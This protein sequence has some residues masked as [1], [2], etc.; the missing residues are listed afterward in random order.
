MVLAALVP[1][2]DYVVH[3]HRRKLV[4]T[5]IDFYMLGFMVSGFANAFL[6][7]ISPANWTIS[8]KSWFA[9]LATTLS[10][11]LISGFCALAFGG[12]GF[13]LYRLHS[14]KWRLL[15]L[16]ILFAGAELLRSYMYALMAYAPHGSL[17]PNFNWGSLAVPASGTP[18]VF[19]SRI[20]GFFGLTVLVVSINIALYAAFRRRYMTS[21]GL[22][23]VA[24]FVTIVGWQIGNSRGGGQALRVAVVHLGE[25]DAL[26]TWD[27]QTWPQ[28]NTNILVLP[29]Y[30]EIR[31]NPNYRQILAQ[32]S[33]SGVAITSERRGASPSGTNQIVFLDHKGNVIDGQ[34]KTF[35]I[36]TGETL[37]YVLQASFWLMRLGYMNTFFT[38]SQQISPGRNA[39]HP[40]Q[41]GGVVVGALACSGVS[42]LSEYRQLSRQGAKV[43]TNSASLSFLDHSSVYHVYARNMA[44]FQAVSNNRPFIQASRSGESYIMDNQ[45][46][47]L[48]LWT[49]NQTKVIEHEIRY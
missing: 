45:G 12:L 17:S 32:L 15:C 31:S 46:R 1:L 13:V 38:Y 2:T 30:S 16:P 14:T 49:A 44:R 6:F 11:V 42:A 4:R 41:S 20:V 10:W 5:V 40:V 9:L 18:L 26:T 22:L 48:Q 25:Q 43:L 33:D 47:I 36:P 37:P 34:D 3:M 35:L 39:E 24:T 28:K 19:A 23:A 7:Q 27:Q 8:M 21:V 29:E